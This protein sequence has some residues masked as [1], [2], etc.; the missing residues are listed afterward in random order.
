VRRPVWRS[1]VEMLTIGAAAGGAAFGV[2]ALAARLI[3][4]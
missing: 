3:G 2:G 4:P 1:A